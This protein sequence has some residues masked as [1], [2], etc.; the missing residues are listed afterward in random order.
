[1]VAITCALFDEA[2]ELI[3]DLKK[4]KIDGVSQFNGIIGHVPVSLFLTRPGLHRKAKFNKWLTQ[5]P[6][7]ALINTG[8]AG[9]LQTGLKV[10]DTCPISSVKYY[11]KR[12]KFTLDVHGHHS[13]TLYSLCTS[14]T[15]AATLDDKEDIY[16]N[17]KS[18]LV[19]MEAWNLLDLLKKQ[20]QELAIRVIKIVGDLPGEGELLKQEEKMRSYFS[21]FTA[22]EKLKI[23]GKTGIAFVP[24]YKRKK[25][26]QRKLKDA[27]LESL[28]IMNLDEKEFSANSIIIK[29]L[30]K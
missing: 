4:E 28:S 22:L 21:S 6:F 20:K 1:M 30:E 14:P 11:R 17:S 16:H 19:D 15:I 3:R 27:V 5:H 23:I 8:F 24:L 18:D 2:Y 9:A 7:Q 10:G 26:L 13:Q 29:L 12:K 25:L